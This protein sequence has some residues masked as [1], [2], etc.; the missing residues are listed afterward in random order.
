MQV[1]AYSPI[2]YLVFIESPQECETTAML[3]CETAIVRPYVFFTET[4]VFAEKKAPTFP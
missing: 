1:V 3:E 4:K 2:L